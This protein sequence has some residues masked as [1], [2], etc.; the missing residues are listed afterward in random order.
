[1]TTD[2]GISKLVVSFFCPALIWTNLIKFSD[3]ELDNRNGREQLV[4]LDSLDTE[5]ALMLTDDDDPLDSLTWRSAAQSCASVSVA[6]TLLRRLAASGSVL[7]PVFLGNAQCNFRL[8]STSFNLTCSCWT[9]ARR[10]RWAQDP[11]RSYS[12][13]VFTLVGG[14]NF[15]EAPEVRHS[16]FSCPVSLEL[17]DFHRGI[18]EVP[19]LNIAE[20][21]VSTKGTAPA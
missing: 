3:E 7:S 17:K 1:M 11:R 18:S 8:P 2:T 21:Q 5:K 19:E 9:S 6:L 10:T 16:P 13:S 12:T 14:R 15:E 4:E 20:S